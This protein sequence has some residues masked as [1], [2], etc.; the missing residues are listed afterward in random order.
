MRL[1]MRGAICMGARLA[2]NRTVAIR[3]I[4]FCEITDLALQI[5]DTVTA[6]LDQYLRKV[7]QT[8]VDGDV[9]AAIG[10]L[11]HAVIAAATDDEDFF[12]IVGGGDP[13][14]V[15]HEHEDEPGEGEAVLEPGDETTSEDGVDVEPQG[16]SLR[17]YLGHDTLPSAEQDDV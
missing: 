1:S 3:R 11:K 2:T 17:D 10:D 4:L 6:F 5:D 12:L 15:E 16:D 9:D 7:I 13:M 8:A 14:M